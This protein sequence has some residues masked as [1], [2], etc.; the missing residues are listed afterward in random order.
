MIWII[1]VQLIRLGEEIN[2]ESN[3]NHIFAISDSRF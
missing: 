2:H 3:I 1:K